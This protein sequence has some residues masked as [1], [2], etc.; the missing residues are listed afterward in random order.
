[1]HLKTITH[2]LFWTICGMVFIY[3]VI[4]QFIRYS[5]NADTSV[6]S[7][8]SFNQSPK[9]DVYP[10]I[11]I[12]FQENAQ[13]SQFN[14]SYLK[15][16]H[17]LNKRQYRLLLSGD[18]ATWN[19]LPNETKLENVSF[20]SAS[21]DLKNYVAFH[22]AFLVNG[23]AKNI[24]LEQTIRKTFEVPGLICFTR[25]FG[26]LLKHDLLARERFQ[27]RLRH[28]MASAF[29]HYPNNVMRTVFGLDRYY[30]SAGLFLTKMKLS[31]TNN[32]EIRMT[33]MKVL[34]KR[35]DAVKPCNSSL[36]DDSRFWNELAHRLDCIP[37]YWT[38]L[39]MS[40]NI[41][42]S[43]LACKKVIELK[44][45]YRYIFSRPPNEQIQMKESIASSFRLPCNEMVVGHFT[46][47][48]QMLRTN[49]IKDKTRKY[50]DLNLQET[51]VVLKFTYPM[52]KYEEVRNVRDYGMESLFSY[53]GGYVGL[54]LG[55]CLL[56][57][58][59]DLFKWLA[60][61]IEM[62]DTPKKQRM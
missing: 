53:I 60:W 10:D 45:T 2:A 28:S 59:D 61:V 50:T 29:V 34:K 7:Y 38:N 9:E 17:S 4:L 37:P 6:I 1:M 25:S 30:K 22:G 35:L 5:E 47:E 39:L 32:Y 15:K 57:L 44:N 11:T 19:D 16:Y 36:S 54:F 21:Y 18:P 46:K 62:F 13:G 12:C 42:S 24:T 23:P 20:E 52:Q 31:K 3:F 41:T 14:D 43:K 56:S 48:G 55:Y 33:N 26:Q 58:L 51:D 40:N 27:L 49:T 8:V